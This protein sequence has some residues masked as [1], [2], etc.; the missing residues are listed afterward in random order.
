MSSP[1][2]SMYTA[3]IDFASL[4]SSP[5]FTSDDFPHPEGP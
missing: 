1:V 4:G 5:A 2:A 3:L